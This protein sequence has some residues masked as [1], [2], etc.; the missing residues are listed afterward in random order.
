LEEGKRLMK[1][2]RPWDGQATSD[3]LQ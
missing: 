1:L 2:L 3:L